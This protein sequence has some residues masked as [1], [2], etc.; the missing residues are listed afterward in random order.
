MPLEDVNH[1]GL[2]RLRIRRARYACKRCRRQKLRVS[3]FMTL[4]EPVWL[5]GVGEVLSVE[6]SATTRGLVH[7]ASVRKCCVKMMSN[8]SR[9]L[10]HKTDL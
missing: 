7:Y 1:D 5:F 4:D 3:Q 8:Q 10:C 9:E 2:R 6:G